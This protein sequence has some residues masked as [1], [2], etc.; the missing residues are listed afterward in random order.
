MFFF[1]NKNFFLLQFYV[2]DFARYM[3][4]QPPSGKWGGSLYELLRP[5]LVKQSPVPL[6]PDAFSPMGHP[7]D[8]KECRQHIRDIF[9]K[10]VNPVKRR[11]EKRFALKFFS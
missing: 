11:K 2:L 5:E 10:L 1:L 3:P 7:D 4:P 6:S 8:A 9:A